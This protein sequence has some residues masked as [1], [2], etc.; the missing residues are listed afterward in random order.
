MEKSAKATIIVDGKEAAKGDIPR[1]VPSRFS[2][3]E[4]LDVGEDFGTPVTRD[5]EV[6]FIF[7]GKID[8]VTVNVKK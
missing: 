2:S 4:T 1:T 8:K 7:K 3:D 5:Y 6:P